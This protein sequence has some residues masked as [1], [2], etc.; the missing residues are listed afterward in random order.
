MTSLA[1][2]RCD[3]CSLNA[4]T[5]LYGYYLY[6]GNCNCTDGD[7][8]ECKCDVIINNRTNRYECT[9]VAD[10]S[11][12]V[13]R[14]LYCSD[15]ST[16]NESASQA[17]IDALEAFCTLTNGDAADRDRTVGQHRCRG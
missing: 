8:P 10:I 6:V 5:S 15:T 12:C 9:Q 1:V 17:D 14:V 11:D 7:D 3:N 4:D 16:Y 13:D 2:G